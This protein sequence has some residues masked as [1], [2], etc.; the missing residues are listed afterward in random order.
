[1]N[2]AQ[3]KCQKG[4]KQINQNFI[5]FLHSEG[6]GVSGCHQGGPKPQCRDGNS[7]RVG[8]IFDADGRNIGE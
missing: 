1:M 8:V 6:G 4:S 3:E 2:N 7:S 5:L